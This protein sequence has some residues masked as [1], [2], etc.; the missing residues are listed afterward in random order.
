M[1]PPLN[2]EISDQKRSGITLL[3][4]VISCFTVMNIYYNQPLLALITRNF[5]VSTTT[6]SI[7]PA[8]TQLGFGLGIILFVPLGDII[9]R[10]PL[11][12]GKLLLVA[13][14]L[15]LVG[16]A[17]N[18]PTLA[19]LSFLLGLFTVIPQIAIP[20]AAQLARPAQRGRT[21]GIVMSGIFAGILLSRALSGALGQWLGW[22]AI[23]MAAAG[24]MLIL[25]GVV[26]R[27]LPHSGRS[28]ELRYGQI[29]ASLPGILRRERT[30]QAACITGA[31]LFCTFSI[32][33][34]TLAFVLAAA[35]FHDGPWVAG[36]LGLVGITGSAAAPL[37]GRLADHKGAAFTLGIAIGIAALSAVVLAAFG[38]TMWGLILSLILLDLGVQAGLVSN[39]TRIYSVLPPAYNSRVNTI[40]MSCYF[41]GGAAGSILGGLAWHH[42][43]SHTA[44]GV[45]SLSLMIAALILHKW[46]ER[47]K[48]Q[49]PAPAHN[50]MPDPDAEIQPVPTR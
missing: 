9:D 5:G 30:I 4:A 34:S 24:A 38:N 14:F 31:L 7:V 23:F 44:L 35:P 43:K 17:P 18:L 27:F 42:W 3:L 36:I 47:G 8:M 16:L 12:L 46:L 32:F 22:R 29:L 39:Q 20:F 26:A 37:V 6:A 41:T 28:T 50:A 40:F 13:V 15:V 45:L 1:S 48:I 19:V 21:I 49:P 25:A 2:H 33:W 10:R 11:I